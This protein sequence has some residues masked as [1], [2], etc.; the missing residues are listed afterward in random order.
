MLGILDY[1]VFEDIFEIPLIVEPNYGF[2][3]YIKDFNFSFDIRTMLSNRTEIQILLDN[4]KI[5][6]QNADV[7]QTGINLNYFSDF[8]DGVFFFY[9]KPNI[10]KQNLNFEDFGTNLRLMYGS[11]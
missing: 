8:K 9:R 7:N 1:D 10:L 6:T 11:F 3:C 2:N 4:S 5:L